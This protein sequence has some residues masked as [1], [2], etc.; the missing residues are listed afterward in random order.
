MK[1]VI[2]NIKE[3]TPDKRAFVAHCLI[4]SLEDK[5]DDDVEGAWSELAEKRFSELESGSIQG[6]T[7]GEIK[8][9]IKG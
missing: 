2:E 9:E 6:V 1:Q 5:Q 3:L 7:W 4:S 8:K